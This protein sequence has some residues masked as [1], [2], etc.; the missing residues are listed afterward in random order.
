MSDTKAQKMAAELEDEHLGFIVR[1][2]SIALIGPGA[3]FTIIPRPTYDEIHLN[4]AVEQ[5]L[6]QKTT[7]NLYDHTGKSYP[8][9][10]YVSSSKEK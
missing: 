8:F 1:Q 4:E 10:V 9:E 7:W 5:G 3:P 2:G 6:L